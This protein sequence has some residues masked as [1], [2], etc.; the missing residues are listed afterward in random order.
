MLKAAILTL[1]DPVQAPQ[2]GRKTTRMMVAA[3]V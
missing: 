1:M 2:N 3:S